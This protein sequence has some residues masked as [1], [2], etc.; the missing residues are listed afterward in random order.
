M[1]HVDTERCSGCGA[2]VAAC[3]SGAIRLVESETGSQAEVDQGKCRDCEVCLEACPEQ[4]IISQVEPAIEGELVQ[5]EAKPLSVQAQPRQVRPVRLAPNAV[6]LLGAA[7]AFAGREILPR[8]A[9]ALLNAWDRRA[10]RLTSSPSDSISI[11]PTQ[12]PT[13]NLLGRGG[14]QRGRRRHR[15]RR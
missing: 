9:A 2:C 12:R 4:A 8:V 6:A 11:R 1:V 7:T 14:R 15:G 13:A 3:P 10:G 5:V